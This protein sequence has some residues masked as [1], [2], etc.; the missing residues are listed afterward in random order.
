[1]IDLARPRHY[2]ARDLL[3]SFNP[4][5]QLGYTSTNDFSL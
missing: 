2:F 3:A 1:M 5:D 4:W